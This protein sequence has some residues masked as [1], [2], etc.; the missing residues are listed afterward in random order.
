M[1]D[2]N[3][4]NFSDNGELIRSPRPECTFDKTMSSGSCI[5]QAYFSELLFS[6]RLNWHKF[7]YDDKITIPRIYIVIF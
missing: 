2:R 7:N 1:R 4:E 5:H 3:K 6:M